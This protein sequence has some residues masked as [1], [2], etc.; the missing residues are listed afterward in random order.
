MELLQGKSLKERIREG[1]ISTDELL[2][3]GIQTSDALEAAHAKGIIHR[4]MKP[5]NIFVLAR[6]RV[7]ILDFGLAKVR[8]PHVAEDQSEEESL[9]LEGVI[10]G[11]T[12]YRSP[13]QVRGEEIDARSDLFSL[14]V[15]L[16]EMGTGK[17]PF[18]GKNRVVLMNAILNAQPPAPCEVN[19]SLPFGL[20]KVIAM[21][22]EKERERRYQNATDIRS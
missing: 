2:D 21:A 3:F 20:D 12:S 8:P 1:P 22:L 16:Y 17:R 18:V 9:T 7:K 14:G 11:T 4:D 5:G 13:E 15:V 19:P 6:E 10:P